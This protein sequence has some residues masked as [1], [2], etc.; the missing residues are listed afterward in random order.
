[1]PN[2]PAP[3]VARCSIYKA[4][5]TLLESGARKA[6]VFQHPSLT[7]VATRRVRPDKR[8]AIVEILLTIGRPNAHNCKVGCDLQIAGEPFP[9]KKVQLEWWTAKRKSNK[10]EQ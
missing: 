1:M 2:Q 9:V 5:E 7:V 3:K 4:V 10:K 6:T 8:E